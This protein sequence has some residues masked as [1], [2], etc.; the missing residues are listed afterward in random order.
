MYALDA[1][2]LLMQ[3]SGWVGHYGGLA[4]FLSVLAAGEVAIL[5]V[6]TLAAQDTIGFA[7]AFVYIFAGVLTTDLF[8]FF[9]GRLSRR[10]QSLHQHYDEQLPPRVKGLFERLF[11]RPLLQS[12]ILL[13]FIYGLR[14]LSLVWL[15][16][17]KDEPV[18]FIGYDLISVLCYIS[19]LAAISITASAGIGLV[20]SVFHTI[21]A[22]G[23]AIV[24]LFILYES[25][26]A[27]LG[28]GRISK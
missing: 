20:L 24:M 25:V 8:W 21:A 16:F 4:I 19:I 13:K 5:I 17:R 14:L 27:Y 28:L 22:T 10:V 15:G 23:L 18:A 12:L 11:N 2:N 3:A 26:R 1:S 9:I 7:P 6:F